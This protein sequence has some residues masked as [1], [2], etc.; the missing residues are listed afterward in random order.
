MKWPGLICRCPAS[1]SDADS[2]ASASDAD[3]PS[4]SKLDQRVVYHAQGACFSPYN[5]FLRWQAMFA[6]PCS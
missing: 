4:S 1:A 5:D 3:S 6:L 2:P